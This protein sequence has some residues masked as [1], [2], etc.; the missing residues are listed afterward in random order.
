MKQLP[1]L[2]LISVLSVFALSNFA[3]VKNK[4]IVFLADG[5]K[6]SKTHAHES[7][8]ALLAK[9]LEDSELGFETSLYK[10]WP[11]DPKAFDGADCIVIFCNGGRR[12]LVMPHLD[13]F[14]K[15]IDSGVGFVFMHYAVEVPKGRGG[16]LMLKAMGGYFET[17]WSVNPHWTAEIKSLPEHPITRGVKPFTQDDEWYF[18]MR[19]QP[20]G[21]TP[22]LS[23]HP[24]KSTMD[25]K[26]GPHSNNKHVRKSMAEGQI[27]HIGWAYERP[28][29]KGRG[30]GTTGAHYHHTWASHDWRTLILNAIAWTSGVEVPPKGVPSKP[31]VIK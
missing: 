6:N 1:R 31:V 11:S 8:N 17:Y 29:G 25:R 13:Q 24:P 28:N 16:D 21:V 23:A 15:L 3:F 12:H 5:G 18:H 14:E 27:Q 26:D 20:K 30:F 2:I 22:I 19:F 10:G 9:A 4:K 7:G